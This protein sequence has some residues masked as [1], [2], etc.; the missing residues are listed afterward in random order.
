M[1]KNA[2][3]ETMDL[4]REMILSGAVLRA[5]AQTPGMAVQSEAELASSLAAILASRTGDG[6]VWVFGYGSLIWNPAFLFDERCVGRVRGWHR[7]FCLWTSLSRGSPERPG[8]ILGLDRGGTCNGIV[9]R[10]PAADAA[11]ELSVLW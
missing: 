4:T 10:I 3:P 11:Q 5:A 8:L 9:Y 1:S 6:E 7:R 2:L